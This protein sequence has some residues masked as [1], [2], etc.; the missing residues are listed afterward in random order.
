MKKIE[1][2]CPAEDFR[3][4]RLLDPAVD[5]IKLNNT[6]CITLVEKMDAEINSQQQELNDYERLKSTNK[7]T[8]NL[9]LTTNN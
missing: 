7:A 4:K 9:W 2:G 3:V 8:A 5:P 1:N 6:Q